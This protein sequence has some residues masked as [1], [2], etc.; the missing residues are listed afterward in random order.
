M[1]KA[2]H[3]L[4]LKTLLGL[5]TVETQIEGL[6]IS[7]NDLTVRM[8]DFD[9]ELPDGYQVARCRGILI[10]VNKN[11]LEFKISIKASLES[12]VDGNPCTGQGLGGMEWENSKSLLVVGTEDAEAIL[13]RMPWQNIQ[14]D[15]EIVSYKKNSI[16]L[17]TSVKPDSPPTTFHMIIAENPLPETPPC[18]AWFAVDTG[19][20]I[21][22]R[23]F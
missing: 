22:L 2:K 4:P 16:E 19:H 15:E 13:Y 5:L 6:G 20:K 11:A 12:E 18:S 10:C 7:D 21:V 9:P 3:S 14:E 8:E 1:A 23:A 17:N